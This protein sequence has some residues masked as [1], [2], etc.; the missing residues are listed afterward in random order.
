MEND[1]DAGKSR[2][3]LYS[4]YERLSNLLNEA[5]NLG[6]ENS[7]YN[8]ASF[9]KYFVVLA[10]IFRF[11]YP[12]MGKT[13]QTED[14]EK[15]IQDLDKITRTCYRHLLTNEEYKVPFRMFEL[16]SDLHQDILFLKQN[17]NLGVRLKER[18]TSKGKLKRALE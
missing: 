7:Q 8:P 3:P 12:I 14:F 9:R 1:D 5:Q 13:D 10:E 4:D 17:A 18:L 11:L 6:K 15:E 2:D 16:L